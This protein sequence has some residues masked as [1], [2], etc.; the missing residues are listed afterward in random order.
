MPVFLVCRLSCNALVLEDFSPTEITGPHDVIPSLA[1]MCV[2]LST[3]RH[4]FL[5]LAVSYQRMQIWSAR[6]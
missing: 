4:Y 3:R 1:T 2:G 6:E 5:I